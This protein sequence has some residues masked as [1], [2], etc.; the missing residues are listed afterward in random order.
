VLLQIVHVEI[1]M[2]FEPVLVGI[3][4]ERAPGANNSAPR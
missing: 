1:A 4:R 3:D 2:L